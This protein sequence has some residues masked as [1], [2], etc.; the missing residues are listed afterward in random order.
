MGEREGLTGFVEVWN[1][2]VS[3]VY[4]LKVSY[5]ELDITVGLGAI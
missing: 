5:C 3:R 1:S 2:N 4:S